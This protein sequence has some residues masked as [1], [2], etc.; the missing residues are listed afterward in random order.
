MVPY[1]VLVM[2]WYRH[3][4]IH[5]QVHTHACIHTN[6]HTCIH[7]C[8]NTYTHDAQEVGVGF[9]LRNHPPYDVLH[10]APGGPAHV[11]GQVSISCFLRLDSL[12]W[13]SAHL[14]VD[15]PIDRL[16]WCFLHAP[17]LVHFVP[18]HFVPL[19]ESHQHMHTDLG[20]G[21]AA[22]SGQHQRGEPEHRGHTRA[23]CGPGGQHA[24]APAATRGRSAHCAAGAWRCPRGL[25][26]KAPAATA[27][28]AASGAHVVTSAAAPAHHA[29][30]QRQQQRKR[31]PIH[32]DGS[33]CPA[34]GNCSLQHTAA[35][36]RARRLPF[37]YA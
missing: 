27:P 37:A 36:P 3:A 28:A 20:R 22:V 21:P 31:R 5:R 13:M 4:F 2:V 10:V 8:I 33:F 34:F 29:Q 25:Q 12:A 7:T 14:L 17:A 6:I 9:T 26:R 11:S 18:A 1:I 30:Q 35:A 16:G 19:N 32:S 24:A 15:A 23:D